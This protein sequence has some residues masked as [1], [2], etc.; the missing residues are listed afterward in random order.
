M[1]GTIICVFFV[2]V[3]RENQIICPQQFRV[4]NCCL[5]KKQ[6]KQAVFKIYARRNG[7]E[8]IINV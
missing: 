6:P 8:R 3:E 4:L 5:Q 1:H 2:E 7:F